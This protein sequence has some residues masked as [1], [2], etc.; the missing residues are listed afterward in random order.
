MAAPSLDVRL[1]GDAGAGKTAFLKRHAT[2][3]FEPRYIPSDSRSLAVCPVSAG[4]VVY[5]VWD[6]AGAERHGPM[7]WA[8]TGAF[9]VMFDLG[10]SLAYKNARWWMQRV[11]A[12]SPTAPL[13]L[14]GTKSESPSRK[15]A[16]AQVTLHREF[17]AP[18]VEVSSK[19]DL[20][21]APFEWLR[22]VTARI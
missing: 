21:T 3:R 16:T 1:L 4:G 19:A 17:G 14:V 12:F 20:K 9:M 22:S 5:N 8:G 13:L 7:D 11:R 6:C 10:S 18:Y 15:L 2:G